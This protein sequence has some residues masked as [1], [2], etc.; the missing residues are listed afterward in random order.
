MSRVSD[1]FL[2]HIFLGT[3][4]GQFL[5]PAASRLLLSWF[6]PKGTGPSHKAPARLGSSGLSPL[7][8][9]GKWGKQKEKNSCLTYMLSGI[10]LARGSSD[11]AASCVPPDVDLLTGASRNVGLRRR[12]RS[13]STGVEG[14]ASEN[15]TFQYDLV[16]AEDTPKSHA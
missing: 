14:G 12:R 13:D 6:L 8:A 15:K 11:V 10:G 16:R 5:R 4:S 2:P 3:A 9:P 1:L 7:G